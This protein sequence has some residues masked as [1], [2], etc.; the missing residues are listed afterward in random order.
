LVEEVFHLDNCAVL[1]LDDNKKH[2]SIIKARGYREEVLHDFKIKVGEG[3]TGYVAETG[4]ALIVP[5]V[6]KD[7]RYIG[8]VPGGVS[9]MAAPLKVEERVIGVLDAESKTANAFCQEDLEYFQIFASQ[10]ATAIRNAR[11]HEQLRASTRNLESRINELSILNEIGKKLTSIL[12]IDQLLNE[13]LKLAQKAL[14]FNEC[15]IL[16]LDESKRHLSIRSAYG[17]RQEVI[18]DFRI[19]VGEGIT[20]MVAKNKQP[21]LIPDVTKDSRYI[22][23]VR[24]GRCEMTVPLIVKD[25]IIGV[26]DAESRSPGAFTQHELKLFQT[27][28][29]QAAIAIH[30]AQLYMDIEEKNRMLQHNIIEMSRLNQ[31]LK[32]YSSK[33]TEANRSLKKRVRELTTLY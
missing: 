14:N 18:K 3:I 22:E 30:N 29:S 20:G 15:A 12:D 19:K 25:E 33:I 32:E 1:L 5:D 11:L 28:A 27:F 26:L 23:G 2:L 7:P 16:L 6:S 31:E 8:G 17:Y 21:I 4:E 9:E 13:I 10:A 24:G